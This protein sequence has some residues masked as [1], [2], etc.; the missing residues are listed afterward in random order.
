MK[1]LLIMMV[2]SLVL[3][4]GNVRAEQTN[5]IPAVCQSQCCLPCGCAEKT[6]CTPE[7]TK[8]NDLVPLVSNPGTN[9]NNAE[10]AQ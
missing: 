2:S 4:S 3:I 7:A 8:T 10:K 1:Y 9:V 5:S 6:S